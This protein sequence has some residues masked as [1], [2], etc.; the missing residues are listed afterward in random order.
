MLNVLFALIGLVAGIVINALADALPQRRRP[1]P[2]ACPKCGHRYGPAGWLGIGRRLW[3]GGQCPQCGLPTRRRVLLVE[4]GA[5]LLFAALPSLIAAP[6]DLVVNA[7][8]TAVLLLIIVIDLEHRLIL[9]VVTFPITLLAVGLTFVV[10]DNT[11]QSALL[12]AAV[13]YGF[14]F[15]IYWVA[16][17]IY[18]AGSVAFG[19]GDVKLAMLMGAMLGFHR[20]LFAFILGIVLGGVVSLL[21]IVASP[22]NRRLHLPYGQYLATAG[23]AMLIWGTE[24]AR[25]YAGSP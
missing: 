1:T 4:V 20:V 6:L 16:Q 22:A 18:G 15:L 12:G 2:P 23:I 14:F 24:L 8:Y 11:W 19:M 21:I 7:F 3:G 5:A 9:D 10:S 25:W 13:G 17:L